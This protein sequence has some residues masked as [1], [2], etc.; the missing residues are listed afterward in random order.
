VQG[1]RQHQQD[2]ALPGSFNAFRLGRI[3]S[4][5]QVGQDLVNDVQEEAA[6]Q[7]THDGRLPVAIGHVDG[8]CQKRPVAGRDHDA[9]GH[10]QQPIHDFLVD[11]L[12]EENRRRPRRG[13][14]P[15]EQRGDQGLRDRVVLVEETQQE[16]I[17]GT[18]STRTS[19]EATYR[20]ISQPHHEH[21]IGM[22][23]DTHPHPNRRPSLVTSL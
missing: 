10:A 4:Q 16:V 15:C 6:R 19:R 5:V 2:A 23:T 14:E 21:G 12:E 3:Q 22:L 9:R 20:P 1:D 13:H 7:E 11:V 18:C 8:R 17:H